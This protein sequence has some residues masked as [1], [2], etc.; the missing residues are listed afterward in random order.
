M[1]PFKILDEKSISYDGT[2]RKIFLSTSGYPSF[3]YKR[4]NYYI[5]RFLAESFIPNPNNYP[6]VNHKDGNKTNNDV[7]NLEW[8]S[9]R[10]NCEHARL[11]GMSELKLRGIVNLTE[12]QVLDIVKKRKEG[13]TFKKLA[14]E[15]KRDQRTIWDICNGKRYKDITGKERRSYM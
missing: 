13:I 14:E 3:S 11:N 7:S 9:Y 10:D 5:H 1:I 6:C 4:K 12:E 2:I 15:Y 8:V